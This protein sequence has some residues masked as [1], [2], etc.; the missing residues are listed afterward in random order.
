[1]NDAKYELVRLWLLKAQRDLAV[2]HKIG[3]SEDTYGA[4]AGARGQESPGVKV[5]VLQLG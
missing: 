2:A 3:G 1:M 5:T 4:N